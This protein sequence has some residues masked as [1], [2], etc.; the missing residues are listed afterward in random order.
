MNRIWMKNV[1]LMNYGLLKLLG[2][3]GFEDYLRT[4]K[5]GLPLIP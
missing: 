2:V 5:N 4:Q 1:F 3:V